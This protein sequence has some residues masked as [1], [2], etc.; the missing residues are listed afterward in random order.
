MRKESLFLIFL[1]FILGSLVFT[2][3]CVMPGGDGED[4]QTYYGVGIQSFSSDLYSFP[5]GTT[6]NVL[7]QIFNY[8][9]YDAQNIESKIIGIQ[10]AEPTYIERKGETSNLAVLSRNNAA[11]F[12]WN[13]EFKDTGVETDV[14]YSV[15]TKTYYEYQS[16][17]T[18]EVVFTTSSSPPSI[19]GGMGSSRGP[20][21]ITL[22]SQSYVYLD[23]PNDNEFTVTMRIENIDGG[24][25]VCRDSGSGCGETGTDED[26]SYRNYIKS[27]ELYIPSDWDLQKPEEWGGG[28]VTEDT[29]KHCTYAPDFSNTEEVDRRLYLTQGLRNMFNIG[30]MRDSPGATQQEMVESMKVVAKYSYAIPSDDI[31]LTVEGRQ[32]TY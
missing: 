7:L 9:D 12:F 14:I 11:L 13:L 4:N 16:N 28:C 23:D 15:D 1:V 30:F 27:I 22:S 20:L 19:T 32:Q 5:A 26:E 29:L 3:G 10:G 21:N 17:A 31:D 2:L 8:G 6:T 25:P 18:L 24:Y